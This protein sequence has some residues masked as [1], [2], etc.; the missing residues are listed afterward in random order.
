MNFFTVAGQRVAVGCE[1][2]GRRTRN[3][4]PVRAR[5]GISTTTVAHHSTAATIGR[6]HLRAANRRTHG[7]ELGGPAPGDGY[8]EEL[9]ARLVSLGARSE[10]HTSELQSPMYL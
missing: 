6:R 8:D 3:V 1:T 2:P 9:A 5:R 10:E 4:Q 7:L